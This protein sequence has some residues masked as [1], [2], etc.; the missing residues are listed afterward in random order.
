[1]M[2]D[3][4]A[5]P[6]DDPVVIVAAVL[7]FAFAVVCNVLATPREDAGVQR[8]QGRFHPVAYG[9]ILLV[10]LLALRVV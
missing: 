7:F 6:M 2:L 9:I 10:V 3:M 1:M 5:V 4:R 8:R